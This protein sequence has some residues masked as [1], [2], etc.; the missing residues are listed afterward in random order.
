MF[1]I[2]LLFSVCCL[3]FEGEGTAPNIHDNFSS[4]FNYMLPYFCSGWMKQIF[5]Y[6]LLV[7]E[8]RPPPNLASVLSLVYPSV[9]QSSLRCCQRPL[10][11][12]FSSMSLV[13]FLFQCLVMFSYLP[14]LLQL[15]SLS[16]IPPVSQLSHAPFSILPLWSSYVFSCLIDISLLS[17]IHLYIPP[18]AQAY[19][20]PKWNPSASSNGISS[21]K[22]D[23]WAEEVTFQSH[24]IGLFLQTIQQYN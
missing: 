7:H 2:C 15:F 8:V 5:T 22:L 3:V 12:R 14:V 4:K 11:P 9:L 18:N 23:Y 16:W 21:T 24:T 19:Q 20:Y 10:L 6:P 13:C 17:S 1:A